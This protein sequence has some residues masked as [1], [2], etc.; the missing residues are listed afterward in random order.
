MK[1]KCEELGMVH[2]WEK[3]ENNFVYATN[4]PQYPDPQRKC[5]NCGKVETLKTIQSEVRK[6]Q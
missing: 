2:A 1:N 6:W 3:I 5:L 4:P